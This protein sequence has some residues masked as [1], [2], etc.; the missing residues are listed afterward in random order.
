MNFDIDLNLTTPNA[1]AGRPPRIIV[2]Q[3]LQTL[4]SGKVLRVT[5]GSPIFSTVV[6]TVCTNN[7]STLL[8]QSQNGNEWV[9]FIRKN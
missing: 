2:K 4:E 5:T 3:A 6:S 8:E 1:R 9:F 7:N